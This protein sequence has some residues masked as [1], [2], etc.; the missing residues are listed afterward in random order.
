[1]LRQLTRLAAFLGTIA[2]ATTAAADT[3]IDDVHL[4][5]GGL[6]RG[7][8][9]E[10]VPGDHV[11]VIVEGGE[12]KRIAWAEVDRVVVAAPVG[13]PSTTTT[14]PAPAPAAT[15]PPPMEGPRVRVHVT[16]DKPV[17]LYRRPAGTTTWVQ[18]C[19]SPCDVELPTGDTYRI[20]GNGL[21]GTKEFNLQ[22]SGGGAVNIEVDPAS[23]AGMVFGGTLSGIGWLV[24][25]VGLILAAGSSGSSYRKDEGSAGLIALGIG[26]AAGVAGVLI[27]VSSAK[28]DI[29]QSSSKSGAGGTPPRP[30]DAFARQPT[31]R[32]TAAAERPAPAIFP[33]L[34]EHRF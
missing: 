15:P 7:R 34:F 6:Y 33:V 28:T 27:F 31:W 25:Y 29:I 2:L 5:N 24:G 13:A 12:T 11:T 17:L 1:M 23:T 26:V 8:V 4:R 19:T 32:T 10:I 3:T 14:P 9:T 30:L 20:N 16:S 21:Q 22:A 18:A